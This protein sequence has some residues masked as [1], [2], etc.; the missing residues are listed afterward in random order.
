MIETY[1][2]QM[3]PATWTFS[4]YVNRLIIGDKIVGTRYSQWYVE[5]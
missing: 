3:S 2:V 4:G 5:I 1:V